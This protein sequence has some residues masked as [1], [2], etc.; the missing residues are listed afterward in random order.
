MDRGE[1]TPCTDV[2]HSKYR[3]VLTDLLIIEQ[4][5]NVF[6]LYMYTVWYGKSF[7]AFGSA[8]CCTDVLHSRTV[9][10]DLENR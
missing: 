5:M 7:A 6:R 9:L 2:L 4:V 3:T 8:L 10:Y 1:D